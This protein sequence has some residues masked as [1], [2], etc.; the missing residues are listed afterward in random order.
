MT[1]GQANQ[2]GFNLA[3][4]VWGNFSCKVEG[5][6]GEKTVVTARNANSGSIC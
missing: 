2:S 6:Q 3:H 5:I 1:H 4:D